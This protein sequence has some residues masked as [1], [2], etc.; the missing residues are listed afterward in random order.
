MI[1]QY[2]CGCSTYE[3]SRSVADRDKGVGRTCT[4]CGSKVVRDIVPTTF[5]LKEGGV[6]WCNTG[7][8]GCLGEA[9][10]GGGFKSE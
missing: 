3:E 6:G 9:V 7:Y 5:I 10:K 1:Y 4:L 8:T 2:S